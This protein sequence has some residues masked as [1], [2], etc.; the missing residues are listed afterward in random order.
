MK[1][2]GVLQGRYGQ[3]GFSLLELLVVLGILA[4]GLAL[5]APSFNR[6]RSALVVRTAAYELA[7]HLRVARAAANTQSVQH[8]LVF[9]YAA[10]RYWAE[11]VVAPRLL[12]QSILVDVVVPESEQIGRTSRIRFLPDGSASGGKVVL[13][14]GKASWAVFVD[15]LSGDIRV[16]SGS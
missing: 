15:W 2:H 10:R 16:L 5:V 13:K 4:I 1:R 9:D 8:V 7:S 12:P 3:F 11:G 6:A 14:D